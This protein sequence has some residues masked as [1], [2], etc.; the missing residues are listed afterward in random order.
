MCKLYQADFSEDRQRVREIFTEY[1]QWVND[2]ITQKLGGGFDVQV[3]VAED[4]AQLQM[5]SPPYGRLVLA[6]VDSEVAGIGCIR[7]IGERVGEIKRMYVRPQ[8]RRRGLGRRLLSNLIE[9]S[10]AMGQTVVRLDSAWFMEAAHALYHSSGFKEIAPYPESEI[11]KEIHHLCVF[12]E[13]DLTA[14]V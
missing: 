6:A 4:M 2:K 9:Q 3:K 5:F 12:M 13:K 7:T 8:F 1:L 10:V 14:Q 11:P